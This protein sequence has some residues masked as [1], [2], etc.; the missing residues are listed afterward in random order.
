MIK[1]F[2]VDECFQCPHFWKMANLGTN[3]EETVCGERE[4]A[5]KDPFNI[6]KWCPL[7]DYI[8]KEVK[9]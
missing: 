9:P 6:P 1:A 4:R 7:P 2:I 8:K 5:I 3:I